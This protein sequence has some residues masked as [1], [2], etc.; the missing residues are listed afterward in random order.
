ML[1]DSLVLSYANYGD[2]VYGP[3]LVKADGYKIEKLQNSCIRFICSI[4]GSEHCT[5][6]IN[7]IKWLTMENRRVVHLACL[8][9]KLI[10]TKVPK[11]LYEKLRF[12]SARHNVN[13][14]NTKQLTIPKHKTAVFERSF[15]Y[16]VAKSHNRIP[17][18]IKTKIKYKFHY[19]KYI[20][21][22]Q[23]Q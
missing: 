3:C 14:R 21:N 12:R 15:S 11:F 9:Q 16:N 23:F 10:M 4:K 8:V 6:Y 7:H 17:D 13:I 19:K 18:C 22:Q 2:S 1:C 20:L 5:P